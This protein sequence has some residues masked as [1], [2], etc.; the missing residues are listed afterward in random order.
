ME[1]ICL[2]KNRA[3]MTLKKD[4][5]PFLHTGWAWAAIVDFCMLVVVLWKLTER[6]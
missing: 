6:S 3:H 2:M 4:G 1:I 5:S